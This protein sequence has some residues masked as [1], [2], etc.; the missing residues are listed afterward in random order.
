MLCAFWTRKWRARQR[1]A[2]DETG[3]Y[4][5]IS[6]IALYPEAILDRMV[7]GRLRQLVATFQM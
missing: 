3:L 2:S 6:T 4:H 1:I 7:L 5:W